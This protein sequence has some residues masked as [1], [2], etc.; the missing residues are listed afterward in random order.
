M[1]SIV[2]FI[3][4]PNARKGNEVPTTLIPVTFEISKN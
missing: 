4:D 2:L 1:L 3:L